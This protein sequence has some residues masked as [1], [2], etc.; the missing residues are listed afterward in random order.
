MGDFHFKQFSIKQEHAAMKVGTD[1]M[2]LGAHLP[3]GQQ[4]R[5]LDIGAGT[6]VLSLMVA[7]QNPE[8]EIIALELEQGAYEEAEFNVS[9]SVF[10]K[11]IQVFQGDVLEYSAEEGFDLIFTNPP[12]FEKSE[13]SSDHKRVLARHDEGLPLAQLFLK[14]QELLNPSGVFY[15][16][17]P[18]DRLDRLLHQ[19]M[20]V[21]FHI[22][23]EIEIFAKENVQNRII[24]GFSKQKREKIKGELIIRDTHG[25]YTDSY[26]NLTQAFHGVDL[27]LKKQD[28]KPRISDE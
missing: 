4:V 22:E 1:A 9:R 18:A 8:S 5:A 17:Y 14:V 20:E 19:A 21:N 2:L 10:N 28:R 16:I 11:Q 25:F 13:K 27:S 3:K 12:F 7:Q 24:L 26:I 6:G 15:M 23:R